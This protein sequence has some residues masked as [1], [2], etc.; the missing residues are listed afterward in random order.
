MTGL[1]LNKLYTRLF[2]SI[3]V[4]RN[5]VKL[6]LF[7]CANEYMSDAIVEMDFMEQLFL[8]EFRTYSQAY[9]RPC[10]S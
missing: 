7:F 10:N 8:K 4:L 3:A 2:G 6:T 9:L 1:L 5:F